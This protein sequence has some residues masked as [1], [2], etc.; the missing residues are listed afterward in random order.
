MNLVLAVLV[1]SGTAFYTIY[2]R[3]KNQFL[4]IMDTNS[5]K[6]YGKWPIKDTDEFAVE[7]IHSVHQSPVR[8]I[9]KIEGKMIQPAAVRF[10]SFGAGMLSDPEEGQVLS[11]DGD[12][13]L[14]TGFD[15]SFGELNYIVGTVSDHVLFINGETVSLQNLCGKN[16]HITVRYHGGRK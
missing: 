10:S 2:S 7:F 16:A 14:I 11:R 15:S 13:L 4:E 8:E 5:G 9:Y 6:L 1:I 12:A 3:N